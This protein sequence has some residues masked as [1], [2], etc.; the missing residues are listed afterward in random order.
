MKSLRR[1]ICNI[2]HEFFHPS[3]ESIMGK[4]AIVEKRNLT[5]KEAKE[6]LKILK[7]WEE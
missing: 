6:L 7:E 3:V 2:M 4:F 5:E 1:E